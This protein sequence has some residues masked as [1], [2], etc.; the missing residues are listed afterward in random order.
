MCEAQILC[1][2][3]DPSIAELLVEVLSEEGFRVVL[4]MSGP[5]GLARL[6]D[7]PDAVIC[8]ID[9]PGFDGL[10]TLRRAR[11]APNAGA[12]IPFIFLTAFGHRENQIEAR[13]LGSDDFITKPIDFELLVAVLQNVLQRAPTQPS[14][15]S[16]NLARS[17]QLTEREREIVTWVSKGKSSADV[18]QILGIAERTVNFHVEKVMRKL[19]VAT[20][21]Q[22]TIACV[23]LGL[24][25]L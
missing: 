4:A 13:R 23:R 3:D 11:T 18:A 15:A 6:G 16:L 2:E 1:I 19:N 20:R 9:L 7:R 12:S 25:G 22:A 21:M 17:M 10:E 24:L 5:D 8:D 14:G